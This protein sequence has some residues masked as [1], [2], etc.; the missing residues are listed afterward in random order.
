MPVAAAPPLHATPDES[1]CAITSAV[2]PSI[3][4]NEARLR[5]G[6][7]LSKS[8]SPVPAGPPLAAPDLDEIRPPRSSPSA[9]GHA[10]VLL[11]STRL[12]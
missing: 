2:T 5:G 8:C 4:T 6:P 9:H 12:S 10:K 1:S 7:E 11:V 3:S